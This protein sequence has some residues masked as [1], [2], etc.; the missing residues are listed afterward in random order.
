MLDFFLL[1]LVYIFISD[2]ARASIQQSMRR[3]DNIYNRRSVLAAGV[4]TGVATGRVSAAPRTLIYLK[5]CLVFNFT[6]YI[7]K[8]AFYAIGALNLRLFTN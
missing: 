2:T 6:I 5:F 7:L 1:N 4:V 8:K 3:C